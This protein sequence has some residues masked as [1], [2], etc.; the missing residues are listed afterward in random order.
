MS[1]VPVSTDRIEVSWETSECPPDFYEVEYTLT[2]RGQCENVATSSTTLPDVDGSSVLIQVPSP[3]STYN[4]KVTGTGS[5][6]RSVTRSIDVISPE[7]CTYD[8][9][10]IEFPCLGLVAILATELKPIILLLL[11]G[12]VLGL[13][14]RN[15]F[16][17]NNIAIFLG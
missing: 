16:C 4:V 13:R 15:T 12:H 5:S 10:Y 7:D 9:I 17:V 6:G 11:N 2:L 14:C 3:Y 1:Y 8:L